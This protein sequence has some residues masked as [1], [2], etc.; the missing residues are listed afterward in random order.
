MLLTRRCGFV[1]GLLYKPA[2]CGWSAGK[3]CLYNGTFAG[4]KAEIETDLKI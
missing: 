3:G 2:A 4:E 1:H